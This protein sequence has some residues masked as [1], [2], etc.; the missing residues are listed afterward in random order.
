MAKSEFTGF[1]M[2]VYYNVISIIDVLGVVQGLLFGTMLLLLHSRKNKPTLYL[3]LFILLFSLEPV[4]NI[5]RDM[6][7]LQQYP[8]WELLPTHFHFLAFPLFYIY[9]QKISVFNGK[10]SSYKTLIPGVLEVIIGFVVFF[11]PVSLKLAIKNSPS[12]VVY[13]ILGL[14]Y[15]IF[16]GI[17]IVK[18]INAHQKEVNNQFSETL[19]KQLNWSRWFVYAS[20]FFQLLLLI[21]F[22]ANNTYWYFFTTVV[23]VIL[24]Y[25]VSFK[26]IT[27]EN[28]VSLYLV[29]PELEESLE[30]PD[31]KNAAPE[32][33]YKP[34]QAGKNK[35][36]GEP[37][38]FMTREEM[39]SV[40]ALI[41]DYVTNSRCFLKQDLTI[42]DIAEA[43]NV[44][45]K[46]I[47]HSLNKQRGI[48]FNN[49]I[50]KFRV[51]EAK[52]MFDSK[53][54][55]HLSVEGIGI[56]AGFNSKATFYNAF[57]KH[58]GCTPGS[59]KNV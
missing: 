20:I 44:H 14:I 25:W 54:H 27:Q 35:L 34:V 1:F 13:F 53:E 52:K 49:Y 15:T 24:I 48:N 38:S 43:V 26:G 23:N 12:T 29:F 3:G 58:E 6:K 50:N 4:P 59:Y 56:E 57:K 41:D 37:S 45:P 7:I 21:N 51:K 30:N 36:S 46:R 17:L 28:I 31:P 10:K 39:Q 32:P 47:S 55:K 19:N 22:F 9:I 2:D 33:L 11:L 5:L 8:Q 40:V 42:V 16:I 18:W